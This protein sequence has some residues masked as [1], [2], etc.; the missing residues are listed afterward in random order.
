MP[1]YHQALEGN[2]VIQLL[3]TMKELV[4]ST[5]NVQYELWTMQAQLKRFVNIKQ[6]PNEDPLAFT[7]RYLVLDGIPFVNGWKHT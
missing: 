1:I 6:Q 4:Y 3:K 7:K 2:D 5:D